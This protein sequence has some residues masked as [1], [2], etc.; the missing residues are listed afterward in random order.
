MQTKKSGFTLLEILLV[1]GII[2]VLAGIV[3]IAVNPSKQLAQVRN[4]Q[5]KSDIKQIYNAITQY[6]I[7]NSAYPAT[8]STTALTEICNTGSVAS[9]STSTSG[10][11][12]ATAGLTNLSTLVPTYLVSIPTDPTG[13]S[14]LLSFIPTAYAATNATGT[15]Y[16]IAKNASNQIVV[17][18]PL[19]EIGTQVVVGDIMST[20]ISGI[21]ASW[22]FNEASGSTFTDSSGHGYTCNATNPSQSSAVAA[23]FSN[24]RV[25][26]NESGGCLAT[27]INLSNSSFTLSAWGKRSYAQQGSNVSGSNIFMAGKGTTAPTSENISMGNPV[28][29]GG[30][31][32][33]ESWSGDFATVGPAI[34]GTTDTSWHYYVG[35]FDTSTKVANLYIDGVL[36]SSVVGT[37]N[38]VTTGSNLWIAQLDGW[39]QGWNGTYDEAAVWGR[40]LTASEVA[41]LYNGGTGRVLVP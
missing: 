34:N 39:G 14:S 2:A 30:N 41:Y 37:V 24:G 31:F 26:S 12:C 32:R 11:N 35:T 38:F 1:I 40:A 33:F 10:V 36:V 27:G 18:A 4:T 7:D 8:L 6:Y 19:A 13:S 21:T 3:I 5:R 16:K 25:T 20:I 23:M 15:G 17:Q 29:G 22:H 9:T 28:L